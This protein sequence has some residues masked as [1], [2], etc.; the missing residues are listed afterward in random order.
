MGIN[1]SKKQERVIEIKPSFLVIL[2]ST[3]AL[4]IGLVVALFV[5]MNIENKDIDDSPSG[6]KDPSKTLQ[7]DKL[8]STPVSKTPLYPTK[9]SRSSYKITTSESVVTLTDNSFITSEHTVLVKVDKDSLTSIVEKNADTKMYPASMTKVMTLLVACEN[10]T[11][12]DEL[13]T[14]KKEHIDYVTLHKDSK[15]FFDKGDSELPGE[16]I[17]VKDALYLC[18]YESDTIACLLL[19]E[20]IAGSEADF[21]ELMNKKAESIGL[22]GTKFVNCT[23]LHDDNHYSTCK[24]MASIMAYAM[25]NELAKSILFSIESY[26]FK[27]DKFYTTKDPTKKLTYYPYYPYWYEDANRF[28]KKNKLETV[29]VVAGKT[30]WDEGGMSLVSVAKGNNDE[31]YINVIVGGKDK[32][33]SES[34]ST[35]EVIKIYNTYA[36]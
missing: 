29:T 19:A 26:S 1:S 13:L 15:T 10:L 2:F 17:S 18:S 36:K 31:L 12:L 7:T 25:D 24:D 20:H 35:T 16:K 28:N 6:K 22:T 5:V 8:P 3:L 32:K 11:D 34:T 27:S 21:V 9:E 30:G 4:L 33:V 14:I 23:G